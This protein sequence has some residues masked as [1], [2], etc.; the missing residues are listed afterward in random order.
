MVNGYQNLDE[1]EYLYNQKNQ[2]NL[3]D[4]YKNPNNGNSQ[5]DSDN[6]PTI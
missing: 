4:L 1:V 6:V 5:K 2:V 3:Y